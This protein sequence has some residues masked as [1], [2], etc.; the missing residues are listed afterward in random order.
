MKQKC[1]FIYAE[2]NAYIHTLI[3]AI[4]LHFTIGYEHPF[5]DGNGRVARGLY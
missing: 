5:R 3:K 2:S 4:T 1:G